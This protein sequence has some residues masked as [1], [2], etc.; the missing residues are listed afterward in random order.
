MRTPARFAPIA[1]LLFS[2]LYAPAVLAQVPSPTN[3][4]VD[5]CLLVC[6]AGD[7]PFT[8]VVRDIQDVPIVNSIVVL[9]WCD[10]CT[11]TVVRCA[12][13][14]NEDY[15]IL[16]PCQVAV[17]T[18]AFGVATLHLRAGGQCISGVDVRADGVFLGSAPLVSPDQ[19]GDLD[20]DASDHALWAARVGTSDPAADLDCTPPIGASDEA[21]LVSHL[22]DVCPLVTPLT[23]S[24][25]GRVKVMYR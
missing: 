3:S 6:P 5:P 15:Q 25:W 24:S 12:Q 7:T 11:S 19:D 8:V 13:T 14:G 16:T 22:G 4:T 18:N 17:A 2:C 9:D 20:V 10:V 1:A 21:I 23:P